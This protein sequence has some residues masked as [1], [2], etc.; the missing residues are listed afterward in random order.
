[1]KL[2]DKQILKILARTDRKLRTWR[3]ILRKGHAR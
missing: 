1:M 2:T 3:R